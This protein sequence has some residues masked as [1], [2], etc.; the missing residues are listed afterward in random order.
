MHSLD[1]LSDPP[2]YFIFQ[3]GANKTNLGGIL[4]MFYILIIISISFVYLYDF[5]TGDKY[6]IESSLIEELMDIEKRNELYEK[7]ELNPEK[8]FKIELY[9]YDGKKLSDNFI[10]RDIG[11]EKILDR[12]IFFKKRVS[13]FGFYIEYICET[14]N[15]SK[16][17][18]DKT[19]FNYQVEIT[20]Q[21]FIIDHQSKDFP[22]KNDNNTT[23]VEV[24]PF[25]F[26]NA[27]IRYLYWENVIYKEEIGGFSKFYADLIGKK[28]IIYDGAISLNS[29]SYILD[30]KYYGYINGEKKNKAFRSCKITK[31]YGQ[32]NRI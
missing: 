9:D 28:N 27:L 10:I 3:K 29:D 5:I 8:N 30:D 24:Y 7:D 32:K 1:F 25:L 23:F 13:D 26:N 6:I 22:I 15:C 20:Y 4:F 18:E 14:E 16:R 31:S 12:G 19:Y 17:E 2:K 11:T 21:G